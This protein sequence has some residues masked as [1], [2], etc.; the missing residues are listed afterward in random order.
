M[1]LHFYGPFTLVGNELS[2]ARSGYA[3]H[4]GI[5]LW[6]VTD[7]ANRF[8]HYIGETDSLLKRHREHLT[9]ILGLNYGL[10]RPDAVASRD[11][12][13]V[14][15]G[16]WR[17][18]SEDPL[19]SHV[20]SWLRFKDSVIPYLESLEVFFAPTSCDTQIRRHVEGWIAKNLRAKHPDDAIHYPSDNRTVAGKPLGIAVSISS[21]M[22]IRGLDARL[23]T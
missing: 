5:Y 11:P 20:A 13:P 10:F 12:R 1:E 7:C 18:K 16:M 3:K 6:T 15:G 22:P 19:T 4:A 23:E 8:I 9:H 2:I 17:D 14:Y 21:D